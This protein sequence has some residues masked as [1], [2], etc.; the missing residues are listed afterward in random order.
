[1]LNNQNDL[2]ESSLTKIG[3]LVWINH[4][5]IGSGRKNRHFFYRV[6]RWLYLADIMRN[7]INQ[8]SVHYESLTRP[9]PSWLWVQPYSSFVQVSDF[10]F[11]DSGSSIWVVTRVQL[12]QKCPTP[13]NLCFRSKHCKIIAENRPVQVVTPRKHSLYNWWPFN[14]WDSVE[15]AVNLNKQAICHTCS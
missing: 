4:D 11:E 2:S 14:N 10:L 7:G 3:I 5:S 1:M 12:S 15:T 9:S 6:A 8:S 13:L